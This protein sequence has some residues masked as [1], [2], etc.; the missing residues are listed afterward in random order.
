MSVAEL[1][2]QIKALP[3]DELAAVREFVNGEGEGTEPQQIKYIDRERA[4]QLSEK[5]L[6]ENEDL[7]RRLAQ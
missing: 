5:I 1:I 4:R 3:P 2:E 6:S 7:F